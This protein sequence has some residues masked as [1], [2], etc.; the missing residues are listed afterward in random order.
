MDGNNVCKTVEHVLGGFNAIDLTALP[1]P[2]YYQNC[3]SGQYTV[4]YVV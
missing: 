1:S 3:V 2:L 4:L